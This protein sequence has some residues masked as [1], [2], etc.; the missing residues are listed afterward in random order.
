MNESREW[1]K[2]GDAAAG[3]LMLGDADTEEWIERRFDDFAA[4]LA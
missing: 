1:D 4:S 2:G 3:A